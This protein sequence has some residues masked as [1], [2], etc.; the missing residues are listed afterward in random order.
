MRTHKHKQFIITAELMGVGT[1][2]WSSEDT[3]GDLIWHGEE[4]A[5]PL[6]SLSAVLLPC[7]FLLHSS[8][9]HGRPWTTELL[10]ASTTPTLLRLTRI[11]ITYLQTCAALM[12][13]ISSSSIGTVEDGGYGCPSL[14]TGRRAPPASSIGATLCTKFCALLFPASQILR[15]SVY[16]E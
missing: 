8:G 14:P 6:L 7:G 16:H 9:V 3:R 5:L 15:C 12:E 1:Q 13:T 4:R 2:V 10:V 11:A